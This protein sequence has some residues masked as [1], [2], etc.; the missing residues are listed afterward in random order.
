MAKL[1]FVER[2]RYIKLF[3]EQQGSGY[4]LDFKNRTFLEFVYDKLSLDIYSKYPGLSKAKMLNE[5]MIKGNDIEV[6]KLLLELL[7]YMRD[8]NFV[9][10][11]NR[12]SFLLCTLVGNRLIGRTDNFKQDKPHVSE[13][14]P[15]TTIVDFEKF[16]KQL[17]A[18]SLLNDSPQQRGFTFEC[19]LNDLFN[20]CGLEPRNSFKILGEQIDGSFIL[21]N[22]VYLLEAKWRKD[23]TNKSELVIFN[24]KVSSKSSFTRG[25]FISSSA[26]SEEA[27][28]TFKNGRTICI[29]LA[30]V[31]E[32]AIALSN[33]MNIKE[34]IWKKVR[35][36]AEEGNCFKQV[37]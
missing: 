33:K 19:F 10:D 18:L 25:L 34:L 15:I 37:L 4:V 14:K 32:I 5:F 2:E 11:I 20:S 35:A 6:G 24:E 1:D 36:L 22:D 3:S 30:T 9:T 31:Q 12:E 26:Y 21:Y 27:L 28:Q 8:K 16:T 23:L 7:R 13:P 29:V 17:V